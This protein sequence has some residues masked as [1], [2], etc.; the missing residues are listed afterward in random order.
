MLSLPVCIHGTGEGMVAVRE[1][2]Q[3]KELTLESAQLYVAFH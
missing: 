2:A 1:E 3:R